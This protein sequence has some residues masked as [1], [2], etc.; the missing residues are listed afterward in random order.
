MTFAK[1]LRS[2]LYVP[3]GNTRAFS[4]VATLA[5][6]AVILDLEDSVAPEQKAEAENAGKGV[7]SIEGRML[8]RLHPLQ[9]ER[10]LRREAYTGL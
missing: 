4:K 9:A 1:P 3:G 8:E 10:L 7:I 5:C 2:V 6:Y